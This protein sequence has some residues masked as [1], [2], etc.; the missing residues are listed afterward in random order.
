MPNLLTLHIFK[1]KLTMQTKTLI[2]FISA[3]TVVS[4]AVFAQTKAPEPDYTFSYNIGAVNDYRYRGLTQTRFNPALQGGA[5]FAH[6]N[7]VY[8]GAW[9]ST[10]NWI[11]DAGSIA[12]AS[13]TPTNAGSANLEIDLYGGYKASV[14]KDI[15]FDVGALHYWY[16]SNKFN[17]LTT[18]NGWST[19]KADTTEIYGALTFGPV[20]AKYSHSV[21]NLFGNA[22]SKN[23]GYLDL[24]ATFDLGDGWS[25][26]PHIGRQ[27]V[28]GNPSTTFSN[29]VYSYTDYSVAVNKDFGNGLVLAGTAV[30]SNAQKSAA[31]VPYY[32]APDGAG[33]ASPDSRNLGKG[34]L[35]IGAKYSF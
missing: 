23:S 25:V 17:N 31:G 21:S 10:I 6:K 19:P 16:P 18:F 22:D 1:T 14:T 3:L 12:T 24:A 33:V 13:G 32:P 8:L 7:G 34:G 35:V 28:T 29:G 26:A 27:R 30:G 9:G 5:D 11:K 4:S 2:T 15:G 20:T